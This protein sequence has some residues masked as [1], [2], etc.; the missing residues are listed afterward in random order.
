MADVLASGKR[1]VIRMKAFLDL[2]AQ[3]SYQL[4]SA[5]LEER[6]IL[7]MILRDNVTFENPSPLHAAIRYLYHA[8]GDKRRKIGPMALIHPIR[9]AT[10]L[11]SCMTTP[12]PVNPDPSPPTMLH[13]MSAL[14]HDKA[15]EIDQSDIDE[16]IRAQLQHEFVD[17]LAKIDEDNQWYLGERIDLLTSQPDWTYPYYLGRLLDHAEVMPDLL[18]VKL[19]DRLDSTLDVTIRLPKAENRNFFRNVYDLLFVPGLSEK[20]ETDEQA[21]FSR[22]EQWALLLNQVF[23]NAIF[24]SMLR[25]EGL[26]RIDL[27][28]KRLFDGLAVASMRVC[29][30]V[31]H[32]VF[33]FFVTDPET[34]RR[35]LLEIMDYCSSDKL[36]KVTGADHGHELDGTFMNYV[37]ESRDDRNRRLN[38]L[39]EKKQTLI[40]TMIA[41]ISIFSAFLNDNS[42]YI[43]GISRTGIRP[44]EE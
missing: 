3:I 34:Q 7:S 1:E 14:L 11:V 21:H 38:G 10:M 33:A 24:L 19:C 27:T 31:A 30:W 43:H 17:M 9:M 35:I 8:Y 42:F 37:L 26:D 36:T 44:V 2:S 32:E 23:K 40:K 28:A 4:V 20:M 5:R 15:E 29:M 25:A 16:N 41:F 13:I 39:Y 6:S 18:H 22:P 12:A